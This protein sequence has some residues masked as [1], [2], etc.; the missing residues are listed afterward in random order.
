MREYLKLIILF[1]IFSCSNENSYLPFPDLGTFS[2]P[3]PNP[4]TSLK[5]DY[6]LNEGIVELKD[7]DLFLTKNLRESGIYEYRYFELSD[8]FVLTTPLEYINEDKSPKPLPARWSLKFEKN[9]ISSFSDYT[10][11]LLSPNVGYY[12]FFAFI[13]SQNVHGFSTETVK[14]TQKSRGFH[15]MSDVGLNQLPKRISEQPVSVN[16]KLFVLIYEFEKKE[17]HPLSFVSISHSPARTHLINTNLNNI[18]SNSN[19]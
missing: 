16:H 10:N 5:A 6:K 14:L 7:M 15:Q 18:L 12:R 19:N 3:P 1:S 2:N 9:K 11:V 17:G 4:S 8:G 13:F